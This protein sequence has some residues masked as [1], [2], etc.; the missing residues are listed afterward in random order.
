MLIYVP[1]NPTILF[2][3]HILNYLRYA[4]SN[5]SQVCVRVENMCDDDVIPHQN[6]LRRTYIRTVAV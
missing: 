6:T 1:I 5:V 4:I 2:D 3:E